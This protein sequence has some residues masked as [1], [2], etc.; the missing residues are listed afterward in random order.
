MEQYKTCT[1]C[2]QFLPITN[3]FKASRNKDGLTFYCKPCFSQINEA[4]RKKNPEAKNRAINKWRAK[5]TDKVQA[6]KRAWREKNKEKIKLQKRV[7]NRAN[8]ESVA[9]TY[10]KIYAADRERFIENS[11]SRR[12]RQVNAERSLVT[13][14]GYA[15]L[16]S[17]PCIYCGSTQQIEIDHI[18]AL[19]RGGRHSIGNLAPACLQCNRSKKDL[20]V[21]EW[22]LRE[23]VK[24]LPSISTE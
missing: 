23:K 20:F 24:G 2:K 8:K 14:H 1:R 6:T 19:N 10:K 4:S 9:R 7:W 15:K 22:R 5:N 17:M 16:R 13:K 21:M 12:A 3:F 18:Q 11:R